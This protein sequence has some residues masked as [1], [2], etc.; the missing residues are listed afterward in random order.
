VQPLSGWVYQ[1]QVQPAQKAGLYTSVCGGQ[2]ASYAYIQNVPDFVW[3]ADW[4][5]D[6]S[7][8]NLDCVGSGYWIYQQ[9]HKQYRGG[10]DVT[11]NGSIV[12]VD[13]DCANSWTYGAQS[14]S[15]SSEGC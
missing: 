15:V 11:W 5:G 1:L 8:A 4:T 12:N 10:H 7:T 2:L 13:S 14:Y 3:G 6:P 9:R